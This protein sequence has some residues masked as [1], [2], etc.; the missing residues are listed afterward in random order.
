MNETKIDE[1]WMK[2]DKGGCMLM[3]ANEGWKKITLFE[4]A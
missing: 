1:K 4:I 2:I 3:K